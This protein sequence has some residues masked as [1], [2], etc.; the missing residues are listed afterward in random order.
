VKKR[1]RF[2]PRVRVDTAAGAH[3]A[4][5]H[6]KDLPGTDGS[7]WTELG[8]TIARM[9]RGGG[10]YSKS[11]SAGTH[12]PARGGSRSLDDEIR[13]LV[14]VPCRMPQICHAVIDRRRDRAGVSVDD[15]YDMQDLVEVGAPSAIRR[16][17]PRGEDTVL[18]WIFEHY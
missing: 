18:R 10:P 1:S 6:E 16:C 14:R 8:E 5:L 2:Y 15:E 9:I 3:I 4:R 13:E 17:S 11:P 12:E 7:G